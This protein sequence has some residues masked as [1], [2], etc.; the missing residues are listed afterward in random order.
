[1]ITRFITIIRA[2][3]VSSTV[4][5]LALVE[6]ADALSHLELSGV[7]LLVGVE[8]ALVI[9][10]VRPWGHRSIIRVRIKGYQRAS[11]GLEE[12]YSTGHPRTDR[13]IVMRVTDRITLLTII[14][15]IIIIN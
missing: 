1:M 12:G 2:I 14:T 9:R 6:C 4:I 3:R 15:L 8:V 13:Q 10:V 11:R 5:I 7:F